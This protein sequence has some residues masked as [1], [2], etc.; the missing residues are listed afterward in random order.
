MTPAPIKS[1]TPSRPA[2]VSSTAPAVR[3]P[4]PNHATNN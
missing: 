3:S 4:I 2:T 1:T